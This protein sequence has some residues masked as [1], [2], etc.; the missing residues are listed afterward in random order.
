M[1]G[2][3]GES[4]WQRYEASRSAHDRYDAFWTDWQTRTHPVMIPAGTLLEIDRIYIR[5]RQSD[6]RLGLVPDP[7]LPEQG[8]RAEEGQ[9]DLPGKSPRFWVPRQVANALDFDLIVE[10]T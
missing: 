10:P 1:Q 9:G 5:K 7:R 4:S 3:P 2:R 8:A 6:F